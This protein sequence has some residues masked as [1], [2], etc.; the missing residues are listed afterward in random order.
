M[1]ADPEPRTAAHGRVLLRG[2][3]T[4]PCRPVAAALP[5]LRGQGT[6]SCWPCPV[7]PT[8]RVELVT[9]HTSLPRVFLGDFSTRMQ[10][11][12]VFGGPLGLASGPAPLGRL[13]GAR[14]SAPRSGTLATWQ[15]LGHRE[16]FWRS[17][18][19]TRTG[20]FLPLPPSACPVAGG[21]PLLCTPAASPKNGR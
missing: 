9:R 13:A 11:A 21:T 12:E 20:R 10:V 15:V 7:P 5:S 4:R 1:R 2:H 6:L 18:E 14:H 16:C 19:A 3:R 17:W 8:P